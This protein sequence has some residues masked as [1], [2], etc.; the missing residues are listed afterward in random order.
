MKTLADGF[1][2]SSKSYYFLLDWNDQNNKQFISKKFNKQKLSELNKK[3]YILLW[4]VATTNEYNQMCK[5]IN[6]S[7]I[8]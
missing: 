1:K 6:K 2:V 8:Y 4:L 3:E 5:R 7:G